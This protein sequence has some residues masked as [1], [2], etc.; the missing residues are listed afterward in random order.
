VDEGGTELD[1]MELH[2]PIVLVEPWRLHGDDRVTFSLN[3]NDSICIGRW[4]DREYTF[5]EV[6]DGHLR[7]LR[8]GNAE[9][10]LRTGAYD[11]V[12]VLPARSGPGKEIFYLKSHLSDG[13]GSL[14]GWSTLLARFVF[15]G[16]RW[17]EHDK[18][19]PGTPYEGKLPARSEFP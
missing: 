10:R 16:G 6:Q 17:V 15:E 8:A 4:R 9:I 12:R 7:L 14:N 1:R 18:E 11:D 2:Y 3:A 19:V 13:P 5:L